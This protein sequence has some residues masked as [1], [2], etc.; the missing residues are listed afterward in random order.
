MKLLGVIDEFLFAG[1]RTIDV[2]G[3]ENAAFDKTAVKVNFTITGAFEFL[4][5]DFIHAAAGV[6]EGRGDN[7]EAAC[8]LDIARRAEEALGFL[9]GVGFETAGHCFTAAA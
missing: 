1:A 6:D 5:D 8:A 9:E 4:E 3:G 7:R 2:D